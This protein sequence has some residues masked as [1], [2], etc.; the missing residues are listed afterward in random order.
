MS[1]PV[2]RSCQ[3]SDSAFRQNLVSGAAY[4]HQ[5]SAVLRVDGG[6]FQVL[7][8]ALRASLLLWVLLGLAYPFKITWLGQAQF[9][10][11]GLPSPVSAI[12][13]QRPGRPVPIG[14][15]GGWQN[16]GPF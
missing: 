11:E 13:Y 7:V 3:K 14:D 12:S 6:M 2:P 1:A 8:P 4:R 15:H 16:G 5:V 10:Y 9:P